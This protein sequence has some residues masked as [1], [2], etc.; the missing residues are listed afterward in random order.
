MK[1]LKLSIALCLVGVSAFAGV[2]QGRITNKIDSQNAEIALRG[3]K[4]GDKVNLLQ[5]VCEG[6]KV[7]LCHTEKV[8]SAVV[9]KVIDSDRSEIRIEGQQPVKENLIIEKQ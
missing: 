7:K 8:G 3:L 6:P 5:Q 2:P 1:L 4:A 9:S